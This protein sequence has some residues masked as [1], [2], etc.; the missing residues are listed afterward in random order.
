MKKNEQSL[1]TVHDSIKNTNI[2]VMGKRGE[3]GQKKKLEEIMI[4][5]FPKLVK[6]INLHIT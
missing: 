4:E 2:Y 6:N 3:N 5:S 1:R